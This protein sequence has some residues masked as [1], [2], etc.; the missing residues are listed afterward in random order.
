MSLIIIEPSN[1]KHQTSEIMLAKTSY[2]ILKLDWHSDDHWNVPYLQVHM[3]NQLRHLDT[4]SRYNGFW[5]WVLESEGDW[6]EHTWTPWRRS[7][8]CALITPL[9]DHGCF[10]PTLQNAKQLLRTRSKNQTLS[11]IKAIITINWSQF[12]FRIDKIFPFSII[13]WNK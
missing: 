13:K 12:R 6:V 10:L 8:H 5:F 4:W 3:L 9:F 2:I 11:G 1:K 7:R